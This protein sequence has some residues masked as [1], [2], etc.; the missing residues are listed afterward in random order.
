M[1]KILKINVLI[2]NRID[3][4]EVGVNCSAIGIDFTD[5]Q[6][7][8]NISIFD[9]DKN[10]FVLTNLAYYPDAWAVYLIDHAQKDLTT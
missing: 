5:K 4:W 1:K 7:R 3:T 2:N 8:Y 10:N 9:F 6:D